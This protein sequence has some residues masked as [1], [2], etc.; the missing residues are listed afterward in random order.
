MILLNIKRFKL[1]YPIQKYIKLWNSK[2][3][4]IFTYLK[5]CRFFVSLISNYYDPI[6]Y[7]DEMGKATL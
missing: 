7:K 6:R 2:F 3:L 4:S 5:L 1:C